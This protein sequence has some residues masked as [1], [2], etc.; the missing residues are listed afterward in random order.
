MLMN[1]CFDL[2]DVD[3]IKDLNEVIK[4]NNLQG[5]A[6]TIPYKQQVIP[7]LFDSDDVVKTINACNCIKIEDKKLYGYNTDVIGFEK[8]FA[9][10]LQPH[11]TKALILGNG[12]AAAAV[13]YVLNKLSIKS[14]FVVRN[15]ISNENYLY[16]DINK[17]ILEEY[18][19]IINTTPLG[20]YPQINM[21]P[22]LPYE[23]LT[24]QHYLFD[25]VYNPS[26]TL[27]MKK[28]IQQNAFVKNGYDMLVIQAEENWKIWNEIVK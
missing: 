22:P 20:T 14:K 12:G 18:P 4:N 19:I 21:H 24:P 27:F 8:S 26:T 7:F 3:F 17:A 15:K 13:K 9:N 6:V 28:G 25:L 11:H 5:L 10:H 2:F 1:V 16:T 23:H